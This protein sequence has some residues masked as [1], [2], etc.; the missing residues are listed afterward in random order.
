MAHQ[1]LFVVAAGSGGHILPALTH[2]KEW[3]TQHPEGEIIFF[4]G[5]SNLERKIVKNKSFIAQTK[6]FKVSKFSLRRWWTIPIILIQL[7]IIFFA[8]LFYALWHKPAA[9]VSTGGLLSIPFCMA[10]RLTGRPVEVYELNVTPGKAI[11]LLLPI[12]STIY[13]VFPQTK[14]FCRWGLFDFSHKCHDAAYP[15]RFGDKD[16]NQSATETI[17]R[18]NKQWQD[19][20]SL[21]RFSTDRKTIFVLGGSQ[22]SALL[23]T[24]IRG[25]I[26]Q[27]APHASQLQIIHQ[28]GAF[29]E[30]NWNLWYEQHDI[31]ALTFSY[32]ERIAQYYALADLIICRAGAGT[33]FEIAFFGKPCLVIPLVA[34]TTAHQVQNAYAMAEQYPKVF[35]VFDQA[36]VAEDSDTFYQ[37]VCSRL[38]F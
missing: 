16:R 14:R 13:T 3:L 32:D 7:S 18:I 36:A 38:G 19:K 30:A 8:G 1:K 27:H 24:L 26:E 35:T 34:H 9:V 21:P 22:G 2:A 11:K 4:T 15:L 28:T 12:A 23:N 17:E 33:L 5:T 20:E 29:E 10:A 37:T 31:P 6:H 25:F